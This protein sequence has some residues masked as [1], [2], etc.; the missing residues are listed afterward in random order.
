MLTNLLSEQFCQFFLGVLYF[1]GF[2]I[3]TSRKLSATGNYFFLQNILFRSYKYE[4]VPAHS[5]LFDILTSEGD[6]RPSS[7]E[8]PNRIHFPKLTAPAVLNN[9]LGERSQFPPGN[10][11]TNF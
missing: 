4:I 8:V 6:H 3:L 1:E 9:L 11:V 2:S 10:L 5:L 7:S